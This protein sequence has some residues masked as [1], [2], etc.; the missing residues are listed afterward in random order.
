MKQQKQKLVTR[1]V[2][3]TTSPEFVQAV[4]DAV[5]K[6][7]AAREP[8]ARLPRPAYETKTTHP[9]RRQGKKQ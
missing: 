9:G 6:I 2:D 5:A 4:A 8:P 3:L 1:K 7:Y